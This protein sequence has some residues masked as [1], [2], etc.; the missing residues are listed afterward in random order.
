MRLFAERGYAATGIREIGRAAGLNSATLYHYAGGKEDLLTG[1]MRA[2]LQELLRVG[3]EA[4]EHSADPAVQL[5][6]LVLGHV[7]TEA[8]NP[9][10]SRV[11]DR[12]VQALTGD[13]RAEIMALRDDYESLFQRVLER[14]V[15]TGEFQ[16]T[17]VQITRLAL[18]EM[19]NG[20]AIWYRGDGR[21][22]VADLQDRFVEFGCRLVAS[23]P[24]PHEERGPEI[25]VERL[26]SEPPQHNAPGTAP[27]PANPAGAADRREFTR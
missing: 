11:I 10:T 19:C 24:V 8:L 12:E 20:V 3:R 26:A 21:L 9:L 16:V 15:R 22:S 27:Q 25:H 17:D 18:L 14:G 4:V 7:A 13:N 2:G 1:I 5:A 23:R 6:R